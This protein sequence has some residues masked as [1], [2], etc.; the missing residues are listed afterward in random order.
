MRKPRLIIFFILM[1]TTLAAIVDLPIGVPL[2]F[3]LGPLKI[4]RI[5][6]PPLIRIPFL[7]IEKE[8]KT[9]LGLDLRGGTQLILE[10]DMKDVVEKDRVTAL[11]SIREI[12]ER[13]INFFGVS[14]PVVQTARTDESF[15]VIVELPGVTDTETAIKTLGETA[16]LEFREMDESAT[17]TATLSAI[18]ATKP[19]GV[20]GKDLKKAEVSFDQQSGA[21]VVSFEMTEEGTK[22]FA[23]L[24]SRLVGQPL[25]IFLDDR[26]L[27]YPPTV[28]EAI[29]SGQGVI[30]GGFTR[31]Q[32]KQLALQL[33]AGA[34]PTSIKVVE[35]R[36]I[37]ALLGAASIEKSIRAGVIGLTLVA[38]F[39]IIYYGI[40]GVIATFALAIY[41]LVTFSLFRLIPV[42]LTLA[43]IAGFI[44]SIGMAVD[45]N[46][47]IFERIKEELRKG[48]P[49]KIAMELGFGRAWD[50]IRDANFTTLITAFILYNPLNWSFLPASGMVRGF[51]LTL[52]LGVVTGLFTGIIVSRNLIRLFYRPKELVS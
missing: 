11:E 21:P 50:S 48:K 44:L 14:E 34:L 52:T 22:K 10:A 12:V 45:S 16:R 40:L 13:R 49:W 33:S 7:G 3:S 30:S 51:A 38:L 20:T 26:L 29:T 42:T 25:A 23:D 32:A 28:K 17:G 47:L 27:G 37:G 4:N 1:I 43:G 39:M 24:S 8:I 18:T 2:R 31:D 35:Q 6:A 5:V 15:R 9:N 46:I 36:N 19:T 41:G